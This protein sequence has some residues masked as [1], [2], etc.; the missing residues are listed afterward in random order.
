LV[1]IAY[2]FVRKGDDP[3]KIGGKIPANERHAKLHV[4][5]VTPIVIHATV[6]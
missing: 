2:F 3:L 4:V 6:T 5:E 1:G